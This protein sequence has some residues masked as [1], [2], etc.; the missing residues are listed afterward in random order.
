LYSAFFGLYAG[1]QSGSIFVVLIVFLTSR[2]ALAM[3]VIPIMSGVAGPH[4]MILFCNSPYSIGGRLITKFWSS[5][6]LVRSL[7]IIPFFWVF[8][9]AAF[10]WLFEPYGYISSSE[11]HH[12]YKVIFFPPLLLG[13]GCIIYFKLIKPKAV[14]SNNEN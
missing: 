12:M 10:I 7:V 11:C 4:L 9:V 8:C 6:S 1:G 2:F 13:A 14:A 3:V 5:S